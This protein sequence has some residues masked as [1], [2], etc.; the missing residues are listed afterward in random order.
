MR[1]KVSREDGCRWIT[2]IN[3]GTHAIEN[4]LSFNYAS[5]FNSNLLGDFYDKRR[6]Y[7]NRFILFLMRQH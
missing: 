2:G 3:L 5:V 7:L 6:G 1:N 4:Y